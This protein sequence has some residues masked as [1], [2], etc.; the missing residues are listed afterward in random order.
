SRT[1]P[2]AGAGTSTSTLST[3]TSASRSP[4]ETRWPSDANQVASTPSASGADCDTVGNGTSCRDVVTAHLPMTPNTA[5][6]IRS[7]VGSTASSS[8]RAY[9][10]GTSGTA[11]RTG[12][13][14]SMPGSRSA[15]L[16]MISPDTPKDR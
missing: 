16:A 5:L 11:T 10:I 3:A 12:G 2:E 4:S 15:T 14:A 9:G 1:T 7:L 13:A 6:R 8:P